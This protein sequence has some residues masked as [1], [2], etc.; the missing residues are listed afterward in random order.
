MSTNELQRSGD[1][2]SAAV[3]TGTLSGAPV[4]VLGVIP[5]VCQTKEGEGGNIA[6]R[7]SVTTVG[8]HDL[9]TTD[10][11]A[12]E[13]TKLY[14]TSGGVITTTATANTLFG[15]SVHSAEG[16]G[17]TKASGAGTVHVRLAKV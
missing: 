15:Y 14:I 12:A 5:A 9:A 4:L 2:F 10:A 3:P 1:N 6:G 7:A 13:G 8:V 17:G 11:V 16:T